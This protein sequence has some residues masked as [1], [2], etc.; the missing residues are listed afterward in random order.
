M[1]KAKRMTEFKNGVEELEDRHFEFIE[2]ELRVTPDEI[3]EFTDDELDEKVYGP[4][5]DIE[6]EEIPSDDSEETERCKIASEI[7][8]ILGNSLAEANGWT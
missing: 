1:I 6:I 7:V 2:S 8:T 4:M 5:C 3:S